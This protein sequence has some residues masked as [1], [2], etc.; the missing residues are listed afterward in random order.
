[1][2]VLKANCPSCAGPI[3][4]KA[5]STIVVVCPFCRSAVARTDRGLEDLGKVA[6]IAESQS[7]LKLGLKGTYKDNRFELTGRAQL[8]HEL[9]GFWD[10]WYATFSNGWVGWLAE[11]QGRFYLTFY[12]PLPEG[13]SLPTF[14]GLQLGQIVPEI[15]SQ[16]PLMVQE[17]GTGTSVAADGEI[18]YKLSPGEQFDYADLAGKNNLFATIDYSLEPPWVF[19]GSQVTLD[20]IGLGDAKP[21]EREARRVSAAGMGCPNCGGPLELIAPD[22]SERVTCPNCNSLLDVNQGDLTYLKALNP[23]P[24]QPEFVAPIGAEGV[25]PGDVK[26]KIIGAVVRSVTIEGIQYFWHEYL[27]YNPAVGFRWLVH[28]DNHW[29]FVEPVNPADVGQD[30]VFATGKT[31]DYNGRKFKIFQDAPAVVEYVKGEFYWRVEQGETVRAVDYVSAP[32]ML[33]QE[34]SANEVNWSV[35]TYMTNDEIE[36]IFGISGLPRPWGVGPNQ[37]FTGRFYYTWG[38]LP[39]L[40]LFVVAIFMIPLSGLTNT[41]LNQEVVLPPMTN[42]ATGQAI[43]S[44]SFDIKANRNVRIT[45]SANVDNSWADL[46]VDLVNDQSQE[47]ESVNIPI[48]YYSGSDSDGAWTEGGR[49]TDATLSSLPAGKYTLRVEGTWQNW[50]V[51]MPVSVKVEQNVNRGVNFICALLILMIVPIIGIIRKIS[52]ESS[53]WKDSMFGSGSDDSSDSDD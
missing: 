20:E 40:L 29:N 24:N 28:S 4:F 9:G 36:K 52:F 8:G 45:A 5:G 15:P 50:Q 43:F 38:A 7:P 26:F 16:T 33:S 48:E 41:V 49:S 13:V 30:N 27:L 23:S 44:Q 39:L 19:V 11:A 51:Q 18:P 34:V 10:E 32:L 3:E 1:M 31:V 2:S 46:D 6:E 53:R 12:Q 17:K 22:K 25:F 14:T 37:P 42:M 35:G 21:V 47:V